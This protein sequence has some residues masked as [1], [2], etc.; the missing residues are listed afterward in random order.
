MTIVA[1]RRGARACDHIA[2]GLVRKL[3]RRRGH[4]AQGNGF[5]LGL[6]LIE[7]RD[8]FRLLKF[9]ALAVAG[10]VLSA[11]P[12][13]AENVV[14]FEIVDG[15]EIPSSLTGEP[16]DADRGRELY[17]DDKLA[18]CAGCHGIPGEQRPDDAGINGASPLA[19]S[20]DDV[21]VRL[22]EGAIR[23]SLVAPEVLRPAT[24]MPSYY[25][26]GQ[27]ADPADPR[28]GEP[29]MTASEIEDLVAYLTEQ[30]AGR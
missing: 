30:R 12:A 16:G 28:Y 21:G 5:C 8:A 25:G 18:R 14:A 11:A 15:R 29:L 23:L 17:L 24:R 10:G 27:R 2:P 20:L 22:S 4:L 7:L 3:V 1:G 9:A 19:P 6:H 26:L 13:L